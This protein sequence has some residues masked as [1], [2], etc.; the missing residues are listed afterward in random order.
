MALT[1]AG[2][3]HLRGNRSMRRAVTGLALV[4]VSLLGLP[5]AAAPAGSA[6]ADPVIIVAGTFSPAFAN[7]PLAARLRADGYRVWIFELPALGTGDIA[8]S[9]RSLNTFADSVRAQTGASKV[10]LIGHSQ[11]GLVARQYVK[12]AGGSSEV[13]SL[14][15]L[16][17]PHY[18]TYV[19]NLVNFLGFDGT[20][21][22]VGV[23]SDSYNSLGGASSDVGTGDLPGAGNPFN[24]T[25]P[26]NVID[27][28]LGGSD[29]GRA[30]L[31]IVHDTA[32]GA[33]LAFATGGLTQTQFRNNI[34]GLAN[35]GV[36]VIVDD[37]HFLAEPMFM[38]GIVAQAVDTVV[39]SNISYFSAAGNNGRASYQQAYRNSG[40]DL[41]GTGSYTVPAAL[42]P[43]FA[44]HEFDP[45][46]GADFFQTLTLP[47]G[48][49]HFS[50]QWADRFFSV[51]GLGAQ[52][53]MNLAVFDMNGQ[54]LATSGGFTQNVGGDAVEVFSFNN[55]SGSPIQ[56]QFAIGKESGPDPSVLKYVAFQP[57]GQTSFLVDEYAT[58]SST[59]Y[60]HA[61]AAGASAIGA[62][63]YSE[64]PPYGVSPPQLQEYSSR[65]GT[66]IL[67]V[68]SVPLPMPQLRQSPDLVGPDGV[69]T[70]FFG[71]ADPL[72]GGG[73]EADGHPNFFGTS[74]AAPHV[75]GVAAILLQVRPS[76][77]QIGRA[78][79][80]ERV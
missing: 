9:A 59:I 43:T 58:N 10:D 25:Q 4:L 32:P 1:L 3:A 46:A 33:N 29:E 36:N 39:A 54:F 68:N 79:C 74:A 53:N 66:P 6:T 2:G 56:F 30:M 57:A 40:V 20:G 15:S 5:V 80:R 12:F 45:G 22:T 49:T 37:F 23:I 42:S 69:N 13:D 18:G 35:S 48:I 44:A 73:F 47:A 65:G 61:N 7:E 8:A 41:V 70:T 51:G 24:R 28:S 62:A 76:S 67:Y 60:G 64:T 38:D 55:T 71:Q 16:G 14:V 34:I 31:Q 11:G 77:T 72:G 50:F 63:L 75:A 52:T 19:A 26:V 27:D 21:V 78:S 17:A